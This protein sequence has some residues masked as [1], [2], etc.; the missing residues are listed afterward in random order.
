MKHKRVSRVVKVVA[1]VAG[2]AIGRAVT[3]KRKRLGSRGKV[4][5]RVHDRAMPASRPRE[6]AMP[7]SPDILADI[8]VSYGAPRHRSYREKWP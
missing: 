2:A 5:H 6:L 8:E 3:L 1:F 4:P 7:V